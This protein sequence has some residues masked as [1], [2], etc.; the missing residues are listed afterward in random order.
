MKTTTLTDLRVL[1]G[2]TEANVLALKLGVD[3]YEPKDD[4]LCQRV[5]TIMRLTRELR[6]SVE[7]LV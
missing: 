6:E 4:D 2:R 7:A 5:A 3:S 1:A